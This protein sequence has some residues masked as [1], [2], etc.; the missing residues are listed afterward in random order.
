MRKLTTALILFS[1]LSVM[2]CAG[3]KDQAK[4]AAS[5]AL[6]EAA[7]VLR[8]LGKELADHAATRIG[9]AGGKLVAQAKD[10]LAGSLKAIPGAAGDAAKAAALDVVTGR[11]RADPKL[12]PYADEFNDRAQRDGVYEAL[13]WLAGASGTG[14]LGLAM[15]LLRARKK[16]AEA[17]TDAETKGQA[18]A[19]MASAV[20]LHAADAVKNAVAAFT[21]NR[22]D[23]DAVIRAVIPEMKKR[24]A[25]APA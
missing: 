9:E 18:V 13:K 16:A 1:T 8:E 19:A 17:E 11:V 3:L 12:A 14:V 24:P 10:D 5:E 4:E 22:P 23:V 21:V 20:E 6:R 25:A 2:S 7:P 15:A